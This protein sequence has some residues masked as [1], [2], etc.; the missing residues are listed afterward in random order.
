MLEL[1]FQK[2][3]TSLP[4]GSDLVG[5]SSTEPTINQTHC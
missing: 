4:G 1:T 2:K 5:G 3:S